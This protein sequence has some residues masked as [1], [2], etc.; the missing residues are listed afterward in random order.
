MPLSSDCASTRV[1]VFEPPS[2]NPALTETAH[3]QVIELTE[4]LFG[5][6]VSIDKEDDPEYPA[7]YFVVSTRA[8][9]TIEELVAKTDTWHRAIREALGDR[10]NDYR[11][12]VDPQ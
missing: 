12:I 1:T 11:L 3:P 5:G 8:S 9:G 10:I 2:P 6:S 7:Q 4:R